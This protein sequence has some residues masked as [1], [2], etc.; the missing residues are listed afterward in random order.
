M[1]KLFKAMML[2]IF[3]MGFCAT[4]ASAGERGTLDEAKAMVKKARAYMREQGAEKA[5]AEFSNPKGKFHDRDLYIYVYDKKGKNVAHGANPRLIG[6]DLIDLRDIDGVY[7]VKGLL[8]AAQK[9]SGTLNF[10]FVNPVSKVIEPKIGYAEMEG[11]YM[12]GS[13]VY[14]NQ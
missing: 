11:D 14:A 9:G 6:K 3:A 8:E 12:V 4:V 2:A 13:G 1:T 7:M 5:F 10:K